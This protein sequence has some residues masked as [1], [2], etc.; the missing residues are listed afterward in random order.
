MLVLAPM[1]ATSGFENPRPCKKHREMGTLRSCADLQGGH[2][3]LSKFVTA[4]Y[5]SRFRMAAK[6]PETLLARI[7]VGSERR[8]WE[9]GQAFNCPRKS[10]TRL[11]E[12]LGE[13]ANYAGP[14]TIFRLT[15]ACRMRSLGNHLWEVRSLI[16]CWTEPAIGASRGFVNT[17]QTSCSTRR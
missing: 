7:L 1:G 16:W 11:S 14:Y 9:N 8:G 17:A 4:R 5:Y 3:S 13:G 12:L 15:I 2:T 10:A 6:L